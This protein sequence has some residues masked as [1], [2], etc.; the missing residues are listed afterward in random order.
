M[1]TLTEFSDAELARLL[2]APGAVLKAVILADGRPGSV[3]FMKAG[4]RAAKVFRLAQD[5]ENEFVRALALAL[6]DH[7]RDTRGRDEQDGEGGEGAGASGSEDFT[8]PDPEREAARAVECT[9]ESIALLR[10]RA[11]DLDVDAYG[12]WLVGI[13]TEVAKATIT[14]EGGFFSKRVAISE[15]ERALIE[16]LTTAAAR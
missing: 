12:A 13:A 7:K 3:S 15:N 10:G 6:R 16:R 2:E 5:H 9:E 4:S 1:T 14:K 8:H 11:D